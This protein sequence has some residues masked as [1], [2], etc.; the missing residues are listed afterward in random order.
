VQVAQVGQHQAMVELMVPIQYFLL[1][2]Q[3]VVVGVVVVTLT[4][5]PLV[6]LVVALLVLMHIQAKQE[7]LVKAMLAVLQ[8]HQVLLEE[9]EPLL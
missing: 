4:T 2:H 9:A 7:H 3:Q 8:Q 1:L 6:V 5:V